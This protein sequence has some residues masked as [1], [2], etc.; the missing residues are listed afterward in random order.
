[1]KARY[2]SKIIL[3]LFAVIWLGPITWVGFSKKPVPR[4]GLL[5]NEFY[6]VACLFTKRVPAWAEWYFQVRPAGELDWI[7]VDQSVYATMRPFGHHSRLHLMLGGTERDPKG[8]DIRKEMAKFVTQKYEAATGKEVMAIRICKVIF[9]VGD[10]R[11]AQP[12]GK[13][14]RPKFSELNSNDQ[15]VMYPAIYSFTFKD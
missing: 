4:A 15:A 7:T 8:A 13:W 3:I 2:Y 11:L 12:E 10:P 9:K 5:F 14:I 6:R 1:M